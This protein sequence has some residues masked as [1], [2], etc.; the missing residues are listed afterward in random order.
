MKI[1]CHLFG[2][3]IMTR[4]SPTR[5]LERVLV[6]PLGINLKEFRLEA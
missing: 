6:G 2:P 4:L 1:V 5:S 3:K